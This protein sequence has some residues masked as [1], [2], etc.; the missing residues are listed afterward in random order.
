MT[1]AMD[2]YVAMATRIA[3]VMI[4]GWLRGEPTSRLGC[5]VVTNCSWCNADFGNWIDALSRALEMRAGIAIQSAGQVQWTKF[6]R[7]AVLPVAFP[8]LSMLLD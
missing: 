8:A 3:A 4:G 1:P 6:H 7:D 2:R 5:L